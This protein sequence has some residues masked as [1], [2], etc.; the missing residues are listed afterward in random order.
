MGR[1]LVRKPRVFLFD[2]PLSNLDAALRTQM[3]GELKQ[4]HRRLGTTMIYVTHDQV[5]AMTLADRIAVMRGGVLQQAGP[6]GELF[7]RPANR[8]V[9]GFLGSPSMNFLAGRIE[10]GAIAGEGFSI[11]AAMLAGGRGIPESAQGLTGAVLAGLRP[12]ELEPARAGDAGDGAG[13]LR[14]TVLLVEP[15]GWESHVHVQVGPA[16]VVCR[17][18]GRDAAGLAAGAP[19]VLR[20]RAA[21]VRLFAG[22]S[23]GRALFWTPASG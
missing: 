20:P 18:E 7:E 10:D 16:R 13:A 6:P 23:E 1:A 5:E 14:G 19:L 4:L 22:D 8:F 17:L 11:P 12:H 21:A 9:A 3:R 2:E 15:G